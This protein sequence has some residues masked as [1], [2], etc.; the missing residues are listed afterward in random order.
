MSRKTIDEIQSG[1]ISEFKELGDGFDQYSYLIELSCMQP[2]LGD[3][4]RKNA[5][6]V[7]G[8]QSH[9]WLDISEKNGEFFF[10]SDSDTLIIK[11]ILYI[12]TEMF[13]GQ[14]PADVAAAKVTFLQET[15]LQETFETDR[16]KGIGYIIK[17]LQ[18]AAKEMCS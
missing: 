6:L 2:G 8:C 5:K 7:D 9:V 12:L 10:R 11:G 1:I 18:D 13:C 15:A 16:Q 3:E 17:T 14:N 4:E